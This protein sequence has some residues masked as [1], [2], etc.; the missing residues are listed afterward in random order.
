MRHRWFQAY[1]GSYIVANRAGAG[2]YQLCNQSTT[3]VDKLV[4]GIDI[5]GGNSISCGN[6]AG[7]LSIAVHYRTDFV[8]VARIGPGNAVWRA[9][10]TVV[11][12]CI[13]RMP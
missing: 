13:H 1:I 4:A 2:G 11:K 3:P 5:P 12:G 9:E 6:I 7:Y 8:I 10:R